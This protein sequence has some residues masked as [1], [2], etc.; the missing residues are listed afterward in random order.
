VSLAPRLMGLLRRRPVALT[1]AALIGVPLGVV[2][3]AIGVA[4]AMALSGMSIDASRWRDAATERASA[5]LG[6]PVILQ[7]AFELEPRLGRE[8]GL[9]I[10]ALRILNPPGFAGQEFLA[11]G[12]LRARIDLFEALRGRLR[13]SSVDARDVGLWLERGADGRGNWTAPTQRDARAPQPGIDLARIV[14]HGL[15]IHYHDARSATRRF[16]KLDELSGGAGRDQPLRLAA[17]GQLEPGLAY[18]LSIEGGPLRLLQDDAEAWPFTL[19]VKTRGARLHARGAL[20]AGQRTARFQVEADAEDPAPIERLLGSALPDFGNA[21]VH[22]TVSIEPDSVRVSSL[23]GWLGGSA[24]SGQLALAFGGA[25]PR[26]TGTLNAAAL[27][28]RPFL[29]AQ[30]PAFDRGLESAAAAR[31]APALRDLAAFD[32]EV[33]LKVE[34]WLGLGVDVRDATLAW[35]ADTRGLRVPMSATIAGVPFA[36]GL[37]LDT[38]APMPT[39]AFQLDANDAAL[40]D[41]AQG[42]GLAGGIE[43]TVG[44]L[45]LRVDGRGET[46]PSLAQDLELS[47]S[48]AAAQLSF[49]GAA[50]AGRIA[51]SLDSLDL[52]ARRGD[53]LRGH[54]HGTLL[55]QRARL[56]FRGGTVPDMLRERALPLEL[57]LAL[58]QARLRVEG[59]LALA[60]S[61]R[62]TA[63][64]FDFQAERA[65]DLAHWLGVAPQASLPVALR[66]QVRLSDEAWMLDRTTLELGRSQ[67]TIEA[68]ST[69]VAGR[70]GIVASVRSPLIDAQE[71]SALRAG[72]VDSRVGR[73][74]RRTGPSRPHRAGRRRHRFQ[75]ATAAARPLR[76]R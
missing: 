27:D 74:P 13:S 9:R 75:A 72:S 18:S 20:D 66:G 37:E 54:A 47:L 34:R 70:S 33:D 60:E 28:L 41:L 53:R 23:R 25:R 71:L 62:D 46:A 40:G 59:T 17:R 38:S 8:L 36:G 64:R 76:S 2:L 7:G 16:V 52:A 51:I 12:E 6:R 68:R 48:L 5:A 39:L 3:I 1:I 67:L 26:L 63:L 45:G 69:L 56:R 49:N 61:T 44:R 55:G 42:L 4:V 11:T 35:R 57:D 32:V 19:D 24:F 22:G 14:L 15:D 10:G 65:G 43:G 21:A 29:A 31:Q 30:P 58:P 73:T 50:D